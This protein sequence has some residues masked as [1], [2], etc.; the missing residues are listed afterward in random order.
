MRVFALFRDHLP[1]SGA[2]SSREKEIVIR[3]VRSIFGGYCTAP[4]FISWLPPYNAIRDFL[5]KEL[6]CRAATRQ[7]QKKNNHRNDGGTNFAVI[8]PLSGTPRP[9]G[10]RYRPFAATSMT[11][12]AVLIDYLALSRG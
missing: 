7:S 11:K 9:E 5:G 4:K 2:D 6:D 10:K 8:N 12:H 3:F 1:D